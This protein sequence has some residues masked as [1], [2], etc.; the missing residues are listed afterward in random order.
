MNICQ[1]IIAYNSI[2]RREI[3][4]IVRIWPQTICPSIITASLNMLVFGKLIGSQISQNQPY[5]HYIIP[6]LILMAIMI[7]SYENTVSS[8]FVPKYMRSIEELLISPTPSYVIILAYVSGGV[9]R[10]LLIAC[11]IYIVSMF[12]TIT[13]ILHFPL[14]LIISLLTAIIFSIAGLINAFIA[15][16]FD[17]I[18]WFPSFILTPM[19]FFAGL[20]YKI[21]K[22]DPIWQNIS[23]FNPLYY[24]LQSVRSCFFEVANVNV[25][26]V[27]ASM[28]L[29]VIILFAIAIKLLDITIRK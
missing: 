18:A 9:I 11:L 28:C 19:I 10:S 12:F 25:E 24:I 14:L 4:R 17:D 21:E 29:L 23:L 8:F 15:K 13:S 16:T 26:M 3:L 20:Y 22:L 1:K 2:L 27:I 6:G 5:I 7:N